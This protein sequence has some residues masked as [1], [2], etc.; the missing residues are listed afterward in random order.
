MKHRGVSFVVLLVLLLLMINSICS[1]ADTAAIDEVRNKAVLDSSDFKIIDDFIAGAIDELMGTEDFTSTAKI[2]SVIIRCSKSSQSNAQGQYIDQ[3]FESAHKHI[4]DALKTAGKLTPP[5]RRFKT[6]LNLLI[7]T[8]GLGNTRLADLTLG[9]LNDKNPI[10]RYWAVH[11]ITNQRVAEELNSSASNSKSAEQ[12]ITGLKEIVEK[13]NPETLVL[14]V[15][16][17]ADTNAPQADELL[18]QIA[19]MRI[20]R[21]ANWTV[22]YELLDESILSALCQEMTAEGAVT[23]SFARRFA[24]LYSYAIQRYVKGQD[25]LNDT[26]KQQLSSVIVEMERACFGMRMGTIQSTIRMAV[27]QNDLKTIMAEHDRL[28]GGD[29]GPGQIESKLNF[30]YGQGSGGN[31]HAAPLV[32]P[33]PPKATTPELP[34]PETSDAN[35]P[36]NGGTSKAT[37]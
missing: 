35:L 12:I 31:K 18:L 29:A 32:L 13:A 11:A 20:K 3:F 14:M 15:K 7:L 5:D 21:Y 30:D 36:E 10:I 4:S 8:D 17:T 37:D 6:I 27:Q 1:A 23:S 33:D 25:I 19:D 34:T 9:L 2:R 28:L 16:F 22:E 26:Q 24:Q